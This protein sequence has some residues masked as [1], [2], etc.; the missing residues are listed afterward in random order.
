M[1]YT[2]DLGYCAAKFIIDGGTNALVSIQQGRFKPV[3]F[4]QIMN[5]ETGRMRVRM[6][7]VG[8]DRY[9]IAYAYMLRL[10]RSDF[11]DPLEL[12]ELAAAAGTTPERV[13]AEFGYLVERQA[14]S[15]APAEG[16]AAD[17]SATAS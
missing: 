5:P 7:D 6:V 12:A 1:E 2:R 10:A 9:R 3:P 11:E 8:S 14:P 13:R 16:S 17:I 4:E 15:V